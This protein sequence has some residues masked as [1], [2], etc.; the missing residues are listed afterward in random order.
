[1][2]IAYAGIKVELREILLRDKPSSMLAVSSKGTVPVLLLPDQTV[3]DESLDIMIWCLEK[4]DPDNWMEGPE[5][6]IRQAQALIKSNDGIFKYY[7][8]R[9]KY[10]DR[11]P[12]HPQQYYRNHAQ[13]FLNTLESN[14]AASHYLCG[15]R[16]ALADIAI[17]PFIRQFTK[18]DLH[19]FEN[20]AYQRLNRWLKAFENSALFNDVMKKYKPWE[21]GNPIIEFC[22]IG[23]ASNVAI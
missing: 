22:E 18:V 2:A 9:Y 13:R 5:A 16:I 23:S 10:S 8:D 6:R 12:E 7:L 1:M 19:W 21:E 17:F 20:S 11:F 14:L 15:Q 4:H 3:I